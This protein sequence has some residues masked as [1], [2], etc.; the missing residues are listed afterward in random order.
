M[1]GVAASARAV[2]G[3]RSEVVPIVAL[4]Y[5]D[6][7]SALALVSQLGESCRFYKIGSELFTASGPSIV[8]AV[9][10][11]G[12][13]VFLDLKL[14]DIPNT[15]AGAM[16]RIREMGVSL[17]TVHASGGRPMIEA[18][19][20]AGGAECGILAVTVLTSLDSESL[21]EVIGAES[22]DVMKSVIRLAALA[23]TSGARGVVC[24]GEE[25]RQVRAQFGPGLE[26]LVPGVRLPGGAPGDQSRIVTPE[27]AAAAGVD[28]VV[29]GRTITAAVDPVAAM[30][31]VLEGLAIAD[32]R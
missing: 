19:V 8:E 9:R 10:R 7:D 11:T 4:D 3:G 21:G 6:S 18:A 22:A 1:A 12:C 24:S 25:A 28:Y 26:L 14:H 20:E 2:R 15:V 29:L 13:D 30:R 16:R 5:P 27:A 23:A 32:A 31:S 17:T